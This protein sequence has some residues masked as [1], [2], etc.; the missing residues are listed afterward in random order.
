MKIPRLTFEEFIMLPEAERMELQ[1]IASYIKFDV[2]C[3]QWTHGQV[4]DAQ[5]LMMR[6]MTYKNVADIVGL[7]IPSVDGVPFHVVIGMFFAIRSSI[8]GITEIEEENLGFIPTDRQ[9]QA[10]EAMGGFGRFRHFPETDALAHGQIWMHETVR[11]LPWSDC[12]IKAMYD[13]AVN[14]YQKLMI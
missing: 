9:I 4:K 5:D 12:F 6:E 3:R 14:D 2:D 13:K 1:T 7:E 8:E 11:S 10:L